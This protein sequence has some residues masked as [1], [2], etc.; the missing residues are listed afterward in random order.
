MGRG[1]DPGGAVDIH[2]GMACSADVRLAGMET[3]PYAHHRSLRP[4]MDCELVLDGGS[5]IHGSGSTRKVGK[6]GI[7]R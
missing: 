4:A 5:R 2:T 6:E 3:H 1:A 7:A